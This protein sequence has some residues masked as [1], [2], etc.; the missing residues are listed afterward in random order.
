[1]SNGKQNSSLKPLCGI[2]VL[3][4]TQ[5]Y[6]GPF[7][8]M[9]LA[10]QG[11]EVIKIEVPGKGDQSRFWTPIKNGGSAY[12]GYIN[13][14][15]YGITL[16]LKSEEGQKIF[17]ELVKKSD[18]VC[19][20]FRV[21]TMEKFGLGYEDLQK[22][23]PK[24]IYASISG[25]GLTGPM[26]QQPCYDVIA[27]AMG[28]MMSVTG[29]DKPVKVGSSIVDNYSGTYL[30]L[31]ICM[32]LYQREKTGEGRRIDVSMMDTVFS[33]LESA[34]VEYTVNDN[35]IE[36]AGNRDHG[37]APFGSFEAM[38]GMFV[39]GCGNDRFWQK[40]CDIME[41]QEYVEDPRYSTNEKRCENVE[42]LECI[43]NNWAKNHTIDEI[44]K[45]CLDV[46]IPFGRV[47]DIKQVCEWDVIKDRHMLWKVHD[48]TIDEDILIP[49]CPIKMHG[50]KDQ[51]EAAAPMLGEHT[52]QVLQNL[53]GFDSEE[54]NIFHEKEV[55]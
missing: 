20:N 47:Q 17:K 36:P 24:I 14:N 55:V 30:S 45:A 40:L 23:N 54:I 49:G 19:E 12:F 18:V 37:I 50:C 4:L 52:D 26:S 48:N 29:Y 11:A 15:K 5:A 8:T 42:E 7:C 1:M 41:L 33:I 38:D 28:G 27:Q 34:V 2:R 16:N 3:D 46:G 21:G 10:D 39:M 44:G 53:L 31:G 51:I 9:H 32:A 13:R 25:Y 43:I 22:I 6:S 35:I